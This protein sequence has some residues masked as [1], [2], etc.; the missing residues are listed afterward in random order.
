MIVCREQ[1]VPPIVPRLPISSL[2]MSRT[3]TP[4][5]VPTPTQ[6]MSTEEVETQDAL[7]KEIEDRLKNVRSSPLSSL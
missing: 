5:S 4:D 1:Y 6:E 7:A 2:V 3:S